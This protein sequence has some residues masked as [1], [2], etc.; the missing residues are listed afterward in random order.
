M[1]GDPMVLLYGVLRIMAA[2]LCRWASWKHARMKK[3]YERAELAFQEVEGDCK[4]HEVR[5]GRPVDYHAQLRLLKSFESREAARQRWL[6]ALRKHEAATRRDAWLKD[7]RGKKLPYTFGL[8]DM[9]LVLNVLDRLGSPLQV[10]LM[11]LA[12]SLWTRLHH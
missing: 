10:D 8:V 2:A 12:E 7:L 5:M 4:S 11:S 3:L 1:K 6:A 9:A